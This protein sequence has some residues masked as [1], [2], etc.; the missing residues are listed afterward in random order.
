VGK[1]LTH[2]D[3]VARRNTTDNISNGGNILPN[4]RIDFRLVVS[5][6]YHDE[7]HARRC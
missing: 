1:E 4:A 2:G 6:S 7:D 5:I 3:Q